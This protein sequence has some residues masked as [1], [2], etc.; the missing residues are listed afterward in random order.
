VRR[1]LRVHSV[2]TRAEH[3]R[4][5]IEVVAI[6]AAGIWAIY[7]FVYEQRVKPLLER[8]SFA[9]PTDVEQGGTING[10]A[11]LTIHKRI[12]NT[13]NVPITIVAEALSVYGETVDRK[14]ATRRRETAQNAEVYADVPHTPTT[15]LYSFAKLRSGAVGGSELSNFMAPPHTSDEETVLVAV[16]ARRFPVVLIVRKDYI[17]RFPVETKVP[18]KIVRAPDGS[19]DLKSSDA[20][21]EFDSAAEY[22]IKH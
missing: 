21:G 1:E 10:V 4:T 18:V 19:Y 13:G 9:L 12:Q 6:L 3:V 16:P 15:L 8:P 22:A 17:R 2:P 11:F 5:V 7:T 20:S 14:L